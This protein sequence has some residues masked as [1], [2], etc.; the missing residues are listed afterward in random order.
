MLN[1]KKKRPYECY[2]TL[3]T[4]FTNKFNVLFSKFVVI[5]SYWSFD[6]GL[7]FFKNFSGES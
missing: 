2:V 4:H 3:F 5:M 1:T 7:F 6:A